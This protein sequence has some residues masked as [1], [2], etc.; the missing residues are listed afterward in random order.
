MEILGRSLYQSIL[1]RET[2]LI[3]IY[4]YVRIY[5]IGLQWLPKELGVENVK[6]LSVHWISE[7]SS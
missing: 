2:H 1:I 5:E 3:K 4:K 7:G 6:G